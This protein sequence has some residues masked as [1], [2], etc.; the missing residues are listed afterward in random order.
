[1]KI[2]YGSSFMNK[3]EL[4]EAG[5]N[6]PIKLEYY[7]T[8]E[9]E[10]ETYTKSLSKYGIEV[11]KTEYLE[12]KVNIENVEVKSITSD[13]KEIDGILEIL[14]K[15]QVTPISAEN[16]IEDFQKKQFNTVIKL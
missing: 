11:I 1:M 3:E 14:K 8:S 5:I 10:K 4:K 12:N 6:Y 15:Y 13:E 7:R 2:F 9:E 16:I